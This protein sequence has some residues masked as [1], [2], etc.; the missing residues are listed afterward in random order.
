M[1]IYTSGKYARAMCDRCGDEVAYK[2]L[3]LEWTGFKVCSSCWDPKTE[4]EF[5]IRH[6]VDPEALEDP[7]PDTDLSAG[8][9]TISIDGKLGSSIGGRSVNLELG[10]ITVSIV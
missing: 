8:H 3:K 2:K 7:R 4:L 6:P 1:A 9:G 5:P 10:T